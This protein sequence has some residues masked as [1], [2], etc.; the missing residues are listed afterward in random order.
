MWT[1]PTSSWRCR[2]TPPTSTPPRTTPSLKRGPPGALPPAGIPPA[3]TPSRS[4]A[5]PKSAR[6]DRVPRRRRMAAAPGSASHDGLQ[7]LATWAATA[8]LNSDG[9]PANVV[10]RLLGHEQITTTLNRCT[11]DARDYADLRVRQVFDA[12]GEGQS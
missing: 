11:H 7:P 2:T 1:S 4:T 5:S 3:P 10:S 9:V 6:P 12:L 8:H